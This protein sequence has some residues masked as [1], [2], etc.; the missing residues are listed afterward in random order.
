[1]CTQGDK[2]EGGLLKMGRK[3]A[4]AISYSFAKVL[5]AETIGL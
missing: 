2:I 5:N 3:K 1:M 4:S